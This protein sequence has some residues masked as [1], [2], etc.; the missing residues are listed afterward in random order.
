M[1]VIRTATGLRNAL[2]KIRQ[3]CETVGF[4]PTMGALHSAH[5][6]LIER[7]VRKNDRVVVS[8]FVNPKQFGPKEDL[9]RYPR[10]F[11][12]DAALCRE[13]G[14]KILY[15]P[16]PEI[17]YPPGFCS[18]VSVGPLAEV[19][20]GRYRPGHFN[21][22]ATVVLKLLEQVRPDRTYLGEKDFQQLVILKRMVRDLSLD[23]EIVGCPT[24]RETDGLA[25]SSRNVYLTPRQRISAPGLHMALQAGA[26]EAR[27]H[28]ATPATVRKKMRA[29]ISKFPILRPQYLEIVRTVDLRAPHTLSGRLRLLGAV[30][31]GNTRLIDNIALTM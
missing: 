13:S 12:Q 11:R 21:G 3:K 9:N 24:I 1:K 8:V 20:C 26:R 25:L 18:E 23:T 27:R 28:G 7:A 5:R 14:V 31:T 4:V 10:P 2:K 6:S 19:L 22:V 30:K 15:N 16:K 29:T 17:M